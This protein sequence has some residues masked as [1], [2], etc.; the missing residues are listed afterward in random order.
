MGIQAG[1]EVQ[2]GNSGVWGAVSNP[3][4]LLQLPVRSI[5]REGREE[6]PGRQL[7]GKLMGTKQGAKLSSRSS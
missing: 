5:V 1:Q 3:L 6:G 4:E 7:I 2:L